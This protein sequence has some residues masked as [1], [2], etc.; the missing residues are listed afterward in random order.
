[1][2]QDSEQPDLNA[3][4]LS[5]ISQWKFAPL[6]CDGSPSETEASFVLHFVGR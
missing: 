4:A 5:L 3:E 1:M 2:V 6:M